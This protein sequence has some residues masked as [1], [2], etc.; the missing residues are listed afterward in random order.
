MFDMRSLKKESFKI[1]LT[2]GRALS[3]N[4]IKM[5]LLKKLAKVEKTFRKG[6]DED[7]TDGLDEILSIVAQVL[8]SNREKIEVSSDDLGNWDMDD[9]SYFLKEYFNWV[10]L[11]SEEKK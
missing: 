6:K 10:K 2:D 1:T 3:L 7:K 8:S 11:V 4:P 9:L 5:K